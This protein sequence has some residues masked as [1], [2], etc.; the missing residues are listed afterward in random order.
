MHLLQVQVHFSFVVCKYPVAKNL[1]EQFVN[2]T[3][4]VKFAEM[5]P[6]QSSIEEWL[7]QVELFC[8]E[9]KPA[10]EV[11]ESESNETSSTEK[12]EAKS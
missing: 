1:L 7:S 9:T 6:S 10:D 3:D 12:E 2:G 8:N 5:K 11:E 4:V